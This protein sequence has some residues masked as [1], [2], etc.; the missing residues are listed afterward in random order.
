MPSSRRTCGTDCAK[1]P[2]DDVKLPS[3]PVLPP[4]APPTSA[5]RSRTTRIVRLAVGSGLLILAAWALVPLMCELHSTNARVNAPILTLRS[6]I[7]GNVKFH[8]APTS[9]A[10]A[11]AGAALFEVKNS[12]ADEDRLD[13]LRDEKACVES[14]IAGS[15]RQ[16][17]SLTELRNGLSASAAENRK[18]RARMLQLECDG[19]KAS[20]EN[21]RAVKKQRDIEEEQLRRLQGSGSVSKQDG[22]A[23]RF[24]AEAAGHSVVQA[25]KIVEKLDEQI[26]ELRAG[27]DAGSGDGGNDLSFS[28]QRLH[29]LDCRIEEARRALAGRGQTGPDGAA[30]PRGGRSPRSPCKVRFGRGGGFGR[31]AAACRRRYAGPGR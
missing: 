5:P 1:T 4:L 20:L 27:V 28:T 12:L 21:A 9:G 10:A 7:D 13:S 30:Y 17:A 29:E 16:L 25:E 19:A 2:A 11:L 3:A 31:L 14:Q 22:S 18:A 8:C 24:A 23:A 15:R 6:P 26:C